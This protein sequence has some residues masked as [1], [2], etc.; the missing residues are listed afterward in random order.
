MGRERIAEVRSFEKLVQTMGANQCFLKLGVLAP[1]DK[2]FLT[3]LKF[4][5][6]LFLLSVNTRCTPSLSKSDLTYQHPVL[7]IRHFEISRLHGSCQF[8][9]K[10]KT[11]EKI[12]TS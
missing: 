6:N 9:N 8:E 1:Q 4:E 7:K 3:F 5:P 12:K 11:R 2:V 10:T